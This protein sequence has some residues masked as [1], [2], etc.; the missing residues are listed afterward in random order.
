MNA[1]FKNK[2]LFHRVHE[3][4]VQPLNYMHASWLEDFIPEEIGTAWES[5]RRTAERIALFLVKKLG[6][7]YDYN[8]NPLPK[9]IGLLYYNELTDLAEYTGLTL[10]A[11]H[12]RRLIE[13]K[14]LKKF[15]QDFG[16]KKITFI[17]E[18]AQLLTARSLPGKMMDEL[19]A[20]PVETVRDAGLACLCG[21]M[22]DYNEAV[23]QRF[24]C[25]FPKNLEWRHKPRS[26]K[27]FAGG[28]RSWNLLAK[29]LK[30][31]MSTLW[32]TLFTIEDPSISTAE[33]QKKIT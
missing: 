20:R 16:E 9:R 32:N 3:F 14:Q 10:A 5:S 6:N 26:E 7:T 31:E 1:V 27:A 25:K 33:N 2:L 8:F 24:R 21:Q 12:L 4:N 22:E 15:K 18:R 29:I 30:I 17:Y 28:D 23:L 19:Y 11:K 13:K